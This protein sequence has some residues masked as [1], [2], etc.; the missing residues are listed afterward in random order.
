MPSLVLASACMTRAV[1][2][3][4]LP[5]EVSLAG[6]KVAAAVVW[7][8][9]V[10]LDDV[11]VVATDFVDAVLEEAFDLWPL[12]L[13]LKGF[14]MGARLISVE[15]AREAT[16]PEIATKSSAVARRRSSIYC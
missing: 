1:M 8:V 4:R 10:G 9:D 14:A 7:V 15:V 13:V 16:L 5:R 11:G 2:T 12:V 6:R 3:S